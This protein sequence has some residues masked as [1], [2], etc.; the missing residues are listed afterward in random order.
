MTEQT[1]ALLRWFRRLRIR[2]E[3]RDDIHQAFMPLAAP[4]SAGDT[5][6]AD[7][8][9]GLLSGGRRTSSG[10]GMPAW[11]AAARPPS[12]VILPGAPA[13]HRRVSRKGLKPV[14]K[15]ASTQ[16]NLSPANGQPLDA[17]VG[18]LSRDSHGRWAAGPRG[19]LLA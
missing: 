14:A 13:A 7:H 2:R 8:L 17:G 4:S 19:D 15:D 18:L 16:G 1:T 6:P 11:T 9:L 10:F 5:P 12:A 3:I